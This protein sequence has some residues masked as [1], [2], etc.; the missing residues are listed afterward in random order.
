MRLQTVENALQIGSIY[1]VASLESRA[2]WSRAGR[3][4]VASCLHHCL[5]LSYIHVP[6]VV[7]QPLGASLPGWCCTVFDVILRRLYGMT[8]GSFQPERAAGPLL[9]A[10]FFAASSAAACSAAMRSASAAAAS[11]TFLASSAATF[12]SLFVADGGIAASLCVMCYEPTSPPGI[13][14]IVF[15]FAMD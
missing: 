3:G 1:T 15:F 2:L 7:L 12:S 8:C 10:S 14:T 13:T 5:L 9:P 11:S 4:T 6:T